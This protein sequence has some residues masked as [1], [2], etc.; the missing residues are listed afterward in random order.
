M[1]INSLNYYY[2]TNYIYTLNNNSTAHLRA[3]STK[4]REPKVTNGE[5]EILIEE[6]AQKLAHSVIGPAAMNE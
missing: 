2:H 3:E 5:C 6:I 4:E 1:N